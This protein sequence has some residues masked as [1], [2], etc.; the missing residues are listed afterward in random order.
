M[1]LGYGP[2]FG[3]VAVDRETFER[4][5]KPSASWLGPWRGPTPS[6]Y[7]PEG[8]TPGSWSGPQRFPKP[9]R[10]KPVRGCGE[11][12]ARMF[13]LVARLVSLWQLRKTPEGK[14]M[15]RYTM[16]SVISTGVS[17]ATLALVYG[18]F[19]VWTRCRAP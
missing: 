1:V 12:L 19:K 6:N 15:F 7:R 13:G 18:V 16:V 5:P 3:L 17:V 10:L 8:G 11:R 14:K 2:T 4:R 9:F